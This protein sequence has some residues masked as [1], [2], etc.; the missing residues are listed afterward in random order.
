MKNS[1]L[2][3][4]WRQHERELRGY[5]RGRLRHE[6]DADDLLQDLFLKSLAHKRTFCSLDNARAWLF[7][8]ARNALI[9][10]LRLTRVY[11]ELPEDLTHEV[12]EAAAVETLAECLPRALTEISAEDREAITRCDLEGMRQQDYAQLKGL[13][14]PATKSRLQRARKRLREHLTTACRVDFDGAGKVGGFVARTKPNIKGD[15]QR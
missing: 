4:A 15:A 13:S 5:L 12:E 3:Q 10:R 14:L 8:M 7:Q 6:D 9:D 1:C 11:V 2:M